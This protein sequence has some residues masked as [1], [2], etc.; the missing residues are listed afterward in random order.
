MTISPGELTDTIARIALDPQVR[1]K[2][3]ARTRSYLHAG[4]S[5]L[6]PWLQSSG[7]FTYTRPKAGAIC[8]ARYSLPINSSELAERL[9][10]DHS[11]LIVPGDHFAMDGYV[12]IGFGLRTEELQRALDGFSQCL[13]AVSKLASL[14]TA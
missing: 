7:V 2:I 10:A 11:V 6:E 3:L 5:V 13:D 4:L 1:P 9:R 8:Y 12:R 14:P